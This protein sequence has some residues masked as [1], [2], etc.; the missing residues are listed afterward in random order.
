VEWEGGGEGRGLRVIKEG[1][2]EVWGRRKGWVRGRA[3]GERGGVKGSSMWARGVGE[4]VVVMGN[5]CGGG[6]LMGGGG[7]GGS[8][9]GMG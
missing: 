6:V 7:E 5:G 3:K 4:G 2:G 8:D 9:V 1:G